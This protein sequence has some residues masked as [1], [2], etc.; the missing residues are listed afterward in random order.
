MAY[1]TEES[2]TGGP[3]GSQSLFS[4][5]PLS[6]LAQIFTA[7]R[8][9]TLQAVGLT[10]N[11]FT[12]PLNTS[13]GIYSVS[14]GEPNSLLKSFTATATQGDGNAIEETIVL[15]S[16]LDLSNGVQYAIVLNTPATDFFRWFARLT[17]NSSYPDGAGLRKV[18]SS[19][20]WAALPDDEDFYFKTFSLYT[21]TPTPGDTAIGIVL[22]PFL[23]WTVD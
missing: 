19:G 20:L 23:S 12:P 11:A 15:D 9:Y 16:P 6:K 13:G 7:N 14:G 8:D 1:R 21:L 3:L 2:N 17:G 18:V 22:Y 5:G 10:I 4:G